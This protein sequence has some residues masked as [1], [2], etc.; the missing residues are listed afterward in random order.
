MIIVI[1]VIFFAGMF[2]KVKPYIKIL[3]SVKRFGGNCV[4]VIFF[5]RSLPRSPFYCFLSR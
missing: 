3:L 4:C 5:F 1:Y 2:T